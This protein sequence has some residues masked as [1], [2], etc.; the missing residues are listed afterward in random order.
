MQVLTQGILEGTA[1]GRVGGAGAA[2]HRARL[3]PFRRELL[4]TDSPRARCLAATDV[5]THYVAQNIS[6][7][8]RSTDREL[9][10]VTSQIPSWPGARPPS[11]TRFQV[12]AGPN[13]GFCRL[14]HPLQRRVPRRA[15]REG[16][17][18]GKLPA[19]P[20]CSSWDAELQ[21]QPP[22]TRP[23]VVLGAQGLARELSGSLCVSPLQNI[24]E[25]SSCSLCSLPGSQPHAA[26][27]VVPQGLGAGGPGNQGA[28]APGPGA[29]AWAMATSSPRPHGSGG[30]GSSWL[31]ED[32]WSGGE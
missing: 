13:G 16:T 11:S 20:S 24:G 7:G 10:K 3:S 6:A 21:L 12:P 31:S 5:A 28:G 1:H 19:L 26:I 29:G 32:T 8:E 18:P 17:G 15:Q 23:S 25:R 4:R 14:S 30:L 9:D 2:Q 22:A 27:R